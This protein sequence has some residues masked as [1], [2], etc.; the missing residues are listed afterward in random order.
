ME[1]TLTDRC[2]TVTHMPITLRNS[3]ALTSWA[4][5]LRSHVVDSNQEAQQRFFVELMNK[6]PELMDVLTLKGDINGDAIAKYVEADR[7]GVDEYNANRTEDQPEKVFDEADS[8]RRAVAWVQRTIQD[9]MKDTPSMAKIMQFT[10]PQYP[11]DLASLKLGIECIKAT[12]D[13]SKMDAA[14]VE[15]LQGDDVWQDVSA[16]EVA[17]YVNGFLAVVS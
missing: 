14:T 15:Q 3:E 2:V 6:H 11:T 12:M 5:R 4:K 9:M 10:M 13:T 8:T 17:E 16:V 1:L 7:K